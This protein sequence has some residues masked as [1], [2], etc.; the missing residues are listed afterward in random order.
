MIVTLKNEM[1]YSQRNLGIFIPTV[2]M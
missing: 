1:M 2:K